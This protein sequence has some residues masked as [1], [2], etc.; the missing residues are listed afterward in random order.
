MNTRNMKTSRNKVM[1]I[2]VRG[3]F[4]TMIDINV[5]RTE[6]YGHNVDE[7]VHRGSPYE[8]SISSFSSG[9]L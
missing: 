1:I 8:D 5:A 7:I 2:K 3:D 9:E 6:K 4:T